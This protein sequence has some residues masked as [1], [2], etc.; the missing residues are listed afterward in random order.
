[1]FTKSLVKKAIAAAFATAFAVTG[2]V[3]VT[4]TPAQAGCGVYHDMRG[5]R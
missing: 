1:M 5:C 2:V 4:A 3:A